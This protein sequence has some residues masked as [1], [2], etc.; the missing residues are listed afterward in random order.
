MPKSIGNP[1]LYASFTVLVI[2]LLVVDY[3]AGARETAGWSVV[4]VTIALAFG[5]LFWW[6]LDSIEG[7]EAAR[8]R[9]L[10][11][12]T[13]YL[14]EKALAVYNVF[15]W[16]TLFQYFAVPAV[17]Q[18]RV[19]LY[20]VLGAIVMRAILIWLGALLLARFHWVLYPFG[21]LLL[22]TGVKVQLLAGREPD[23][24]GNPLLRW[25]RR[26]LRITE[27]YHGE[28]FFVPLQGQRHATPLFLVLVLV[29]ATDL[30]FA[31]DATSAILA[32]TRDP[33]IVFSSNIFAILGLRTMSFLLAG[34]A[35]RFHLLKY[36]L[37]AVLV[38]IGARMLLLDVLGIP[39]G[40][41]L[42][43]VG[44]MLAAAVA[45]SLM[46][47]RADPPRR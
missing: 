4:W 30:V 41:A 21:L 25:M 5:A 45:A 19:L 38:F 32:V 36:G 43:V 26:R 11:Y 29:E 12:F 17:L 3:K 22:A 10:E 35:Q 16:I 31:L 28:R 7:P 18:R 14:I 46:A 44:L 40:I 42:G 13:G 27:R 47:S 6:Y 33:F 23:L 2:V 34:M 24:A 37:A 20:A 39:I 9:A 8:T 1:G 15:V